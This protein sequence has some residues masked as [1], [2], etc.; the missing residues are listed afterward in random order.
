MHD[1]LIPAVIICKHCTMIKND[2]EQCGNCLGT[3]EITAYVRPDDAEII[4]QGG[5][6]SPNG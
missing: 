4:A 1:D 2:H 3:E 5:I 6:G